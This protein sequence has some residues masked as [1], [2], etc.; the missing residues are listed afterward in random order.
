MELEWANDGV[1]NRSLVCWLTPAVRE[2]VASVGK[3][4]DDRWS[5]VLS[6]NIAPMDLK[7]QSLY[8]TEQEAK[9]ATE[10]IVKVLIIGG[11]HRGR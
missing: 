4:T 2:R 8:D 9:E 3:R 11:H 1:Q 5:I 6:Y 7:Y 10:E